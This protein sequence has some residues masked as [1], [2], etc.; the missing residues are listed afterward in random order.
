MNVSNR[1][2]LRRPN[3][4]LCIGDLKDQIILHV[5]DLTEPVFGEVDATED[6][7]KISNVWASIKTTS[8][9]AFFA[10]ISGDVSVTHE[11][12]IRYRDDVSAETWIELK[13]GSLLDIVAIENLEE[14]DEWLRLQCSERGSKALGSA[15]A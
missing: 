8:G 3:R 13:T 2:V 10:G 6:F 14:K 12:S 5:R 11:I 1:T 15:Q 7:N 9:K 4:T